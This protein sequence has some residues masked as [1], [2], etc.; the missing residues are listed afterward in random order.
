MVAPGPPSV[1][2]TGPTPDPVSTARAAAP[3][4]GGSG[5]VAE[6]KVLS[7]SDMARLKGYEGDP[8]GDCGQ[9]TMVRNGTCLK[10]VT[11]GTTTGCS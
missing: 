3:L 9:F 4:S 2:T 10:C 8:C 7:A 1:A 6:V 11:C 5:A